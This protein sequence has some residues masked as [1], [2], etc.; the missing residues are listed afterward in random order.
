M[1]AAPENPPRHG[2]GDRAQ[3]GGGGSPPAQRLIVYRARQLRK[4]MS[5][6]ERML[7]RELRQRPEGLKFRKQHPIGNYVVDFC[8]LGARLI[9]EVDGE[10]HNMG[11]RPAR[12]LIRSKF[13]EDSG[14]KVLRIS[15]RRVLADV[16]GTAGAIVARAV[17]PHHHPADGPPPRAG[18]DF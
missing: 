3:R 1:I 18:E 16:V 8:C 4:E 12:D 13:L 14:F 5:L 10:V 15:A 6:P 2:E 17:S 11:D 7:W 9:V